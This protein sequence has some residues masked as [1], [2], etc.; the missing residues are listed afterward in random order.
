MN[1]ETSDAAMT[2]Y[3]PKKKKLPKKLF[4][5]VF[6]FPIFFLSF[7]FKS[8]CFLSFH[9]ERFLIS[10]QKS[11]F[12]KRLPKHNVCL[13]FSALG[14]GGSFNYSRMQFTDIVTFDDRVFKF[15]INKI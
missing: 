10:E 2:C 12:E 3:G 4:C 14:K 1:H 7:S 13:S 8:I 6:Y 9:L 11:A 5:L 15:R